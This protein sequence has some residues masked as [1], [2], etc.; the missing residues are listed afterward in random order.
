M[1]TGEPDLGS[2][3][4]SGP[5]APEKGRRGL[6]GEGKRALEGRAV[7]E[8]RTRPLRVKP[9][10]CIWVSVGS[11]KGGAH[12]SGEFGDG[13]RPQPLDGEMVLAPET[14]KCRSDVVE[15]KPGAQVQ[16]AERKTHK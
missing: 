15:G 1:H 14:Q 13:A 8:A 3:A 5:K 16:H 4:V 10:L 2:R 12:G 6:A 7:G 9:S 11:S